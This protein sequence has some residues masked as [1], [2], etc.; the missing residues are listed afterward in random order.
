M[1]QSL[2]YAVVATEFSM[3][4]IM[5]IIKIAKERGYKGNPGKEDRPIAKDFNALQ[6]W[7]VAH[8]PGEFELI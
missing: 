8:Y 3:A 5:P 4:D 6:E 2:R 1:P 7:L